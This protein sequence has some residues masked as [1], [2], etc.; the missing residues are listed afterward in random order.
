MTKMERY[1][2]EHD[3]DCDEDRSN[4]FSSEDRRC[5][6]SKEYAEALR[7]AWHDQESEDSYDDD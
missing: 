1:L 5:A 2:F 3:L 6:Y 4:K 7:E